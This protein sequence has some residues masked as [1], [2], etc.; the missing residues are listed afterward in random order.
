LFT[1]FPAAFA[2]VSVALFWPLHLVLVGIV[3]R[4]ASFVFRAYGSPDAVVQLAWSR[5]FGA[6]S[7]VTPMLLG[8]CVGA[9]SAGGIRVGPGGVA[10]PSPAWLEPFAL[11]VG[12]LALLLCAYL[13]AVYLAWESPGVLQEDFRRRALGTWLVAGIAS[14]AVLLLARRDAPRLWSSLTSLPVGLIVIAGGV[15]APASAFAL[16]RRRFSLARVLAAGQVALLLIGWG[17]AQ[18]P[19]LVFPDLTLWQSAAPAAT[20]AFA[21]WTIP[22][23]L[24]VLLPSLWFL[25]SVFKGRNPGASVPHSEPP[26]SRIDKMI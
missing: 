15:L 7:A 6:A 1:C 18:F 14:I 25:F 24:G 17:V 3:L 11:A 9:V 2:A 4:G 23:G 19:Y 22:A 16:V 20:L 10:G 13:A 5:V 12:A 21:A 8:A 26:R